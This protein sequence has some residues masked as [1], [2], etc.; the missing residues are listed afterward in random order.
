MDL[1]GWATPTGTFPFFK[2]PSA[3][4]AY[5]RKEGFS[6]LIATVPAAD[7]CLAPNLR[8]YD[9]RYG[10]PPDSVY[11]RYFLD[12]TDD[13]TKIERRAPDAV[14]QV[15]QL[16]VIDLPRAQAALDPSAAR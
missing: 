3:K 14:T 1:P 8:R 15:G 9:E 2:G 11:A 13:V 16:L 5:L 6:H 10:K 4:V 7:L 12:W